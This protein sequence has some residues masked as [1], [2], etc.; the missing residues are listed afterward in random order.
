M[1]ILIEPDSDRAD[2]RDRGEA[3]TKKHS[4][5]F[6]STLSVLVL[7]QLPLTMTALALGWLGISSFQYQRPPMERIGLYVSAVN[8]FEAIRAYRFPVAYWLGI[9]EQLPTVNLD[10]KQKNYRALE[11]GASN[12]QAVNNKQ[13]DGE[14]LH[15]DITV[16]ADL[17]HGD[18]SVPVKIR[19][20][21]DRGIHW[22]H[23]DSWSF[24]VEI[25]DEG[26]LFG[27]R[28]FS[29]Q[30]PITR[31]YVYEWFYHKLLKRQGLI[32]L[33]Y[34][35][36]ELVVNGK[37]QGIYAL[38]EHFD[39]VLLENNNRRE[40]PILRFAEIESGDWF[41]MTVTP[42]SKTRWSER[43]PEMLRQATNLLEDFQYGRRTVSET[44]DIEL[45]ARFFAISDLTDTIHGTLAKSVKFY[46]NPINRKL[47]P[48]GFDAH[49]YGRRFPAL[50]SEMSDFRSPG[51]YSLAGYY[52]N[53]FG[54]DIHNKL[55]FYEAYVKE[56]ERLSDPAFLDTLFAEIGPE[57]DEKL[58]AMYAEIPWHDAWTGHPLTSGATFLFY[59]S[60]E[61][62][63][64][65]QL[66]IRKQL[67]PIAGVTAYIEDIDQQRIVLQLANSQKLP[68]DVIEAIHNGI[69]YRPVTRLVLN[70]KPRY[71]PL[72]FARV[73]FEAVGTQPPAKK[74]EKT[75][76][77]VQPKPRKSLIRYRVPGSKQIAEH[78]LF[79]WLPSVLQDPTRVVYHRSMDLE[80]RPFLEIN[81][82][83]KTVTFASGSWEVSRDVVIPEGYTLVAQ[84][85]TRIDLRNGARLVSYSP[86]DFK[87][88]KSNPIIFSSSDKSGKGLVVLEASSRS[89]LDFVRFEDLALAEDDDWALPGVVTFHRSDVDIQNCFF[90]NNQSED[91][92]NIV[93]SN[94]TITD[95][96]FENTFGDAF[97]SDFSD[98]RVENTR[99]K[100]IGNDAIDVS[101]S[102]ITVRKTTINGAGDKGISV[103]ES[104]R[105]EGEFLTIGGTKIGVA[106]KDHS[107]FQG[108]TLTI[109]N[110][111]VGFA[112]FQKKSEYGPANADVWRTRLDNV[113][114]SH[115]LEE[116]STLSWEGTPVAANKVELKKVLYPE[117]NVAPA[118]PTASTPQ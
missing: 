40:A 41:Q 112:L 13:K 62:L 101:G 79:N 43:N 14:F 2:T 17:R 38:E 32:G 11:Y 49:F 68:L 108:T 12:D 9:A 115:W 55:E 85:G 92:L 117:D 98:G 29:L 1:A 100:N 39:K 16:N 72:H 65:R 18:E 67:R 50:I 110:S 23:P 54:P 26:S 30:K 77:L 42:Y 106:V 96:R 52:N 7:V 89:K 15:R 5:R 75:V 114:E 60:R 63:Y 91:S 51:G 111:K 87:G 69:I 31:N 8:T 22:K 27:M 20:K 73:E 107:H 82:S 58:D 104:S 35:F 34:D 10:I 28:S 53:F 21:G 4:S 70:E 37:S 25:R 86:L 84:A 93:R 71:E 94:F 59:F 19:L 102:E 3:R 81:E 44:F 97:D 116:G 45:M 99:F 103:G 80:S 78:D 33:R 109:R 113:N 57:L 66:F 47:E 88:T 48:I 95:S 74:L 61:N 118:P 56:L 36:I 90:G 24:R 46:Y 64:E 105:L 83:D 76:R 6:R